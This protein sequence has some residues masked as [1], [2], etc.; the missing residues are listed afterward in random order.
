MP[1]E[2]PAENNGKK[3]KRVW[4][5]LTEV[6]FIIFLFYSNL[7]MGEF[8][9]SGTAQKHNIIWAVEDIFT[10][11]NFCIALISGLIGHLLFDFLKKRL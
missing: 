6:V 7:L 3:H 9:R 5:V 2:Q 8:N 11:T 4:I 10:V 1:Q